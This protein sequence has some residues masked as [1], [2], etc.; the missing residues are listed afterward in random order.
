MPFQ[1]QARSRTFTSRDSTLTRA[2]FPSPSARRNPPPLA[3]QRARCARE[4]QMPRWC[5]QVLWGLLIV[6]VV[7]WPTVVS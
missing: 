3:V 5:V 4:R 2:C 1:H 6:M 7:G